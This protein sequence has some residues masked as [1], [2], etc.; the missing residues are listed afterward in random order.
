MAN[1]NIYITPSLV[2]DVMV[3]D[4][5]FFY[6]TQVQNKFEILQN[7][8]YFNIIM[9]SWSLST[10]SLKLIRRRK[11]LG[12]REND[13][14]NMS[15]IIFELSFSTLKKGWRYWSSIRYNFVLFLVQVPIPFFFFVLIEYIFLCW[16][17][18]EK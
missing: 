17:S 11:D 2:S 13:K 14:L 10:S 4:R 6:P 7:K 5:P 8:K 15:V 3:R 16:S 12:R 9:E 18:L 1:T